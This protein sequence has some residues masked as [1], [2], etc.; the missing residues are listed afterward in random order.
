MTSLDLG[1]N[2]D[3]SNVTDMGAM[4]NYSGYTAMTSLDLGDKFNTSNVILMGGMFHSCGYT[5]MTSLDL[6]D[7][8]DTSN[9][10][11]M[12]GM[13][14]ECGHE[15]MTSLNLGDKFNTSEVT[16]MQYMFYG[17]GYTEMASLN[18]GEK[19]DTSSVTDMSYMFQLCGYN[20]MTDLDLGPAFTNIPSGKVTDSEENIVDAY[21]NMFQNTGKSGAIIYAPEAIY[22]NSTSFKLNGTDTSTEAGTIAVSSGRTVNPKYRPEWTVTGTTIDATN[23]ALKINIKGSTNSNYTSDVTTALT[24]EDISIWIDGTEV[25]GVTA[26][27]ST[28]NPTTGASITHTITITN[29]EETL[30]QAGKS[31]KEWSG[32]IALKIAGRGE[33]TDTYTKN[34][35]TDSYGNQ[36]MSATDETGTWV[37]V[38][39]K[40]DTIISENTPGKL[41]ADFITPEFTYEYA[42][43]TIDHGTKTV[44]IKFSVADKYFNTSKLTTDSTASNIAVE[45]DGKTTENA[46]KEL[47]KIEDIKATI[48]GKADTKVGETYQ[49][50]ISNLDQGE[51][52][53]YSGIT[54]L[55]F[56]EGVITDKSGNNSIATTITIGIDTPK[57]D[58]G[59]TSGVIVDV[60]SP[61][62]K[63]QNLLVDKTNKK[64]TIELIATDKYLTGV[65]NSTLTINDITL[66]VDGDVNANT[67]ITK[68]LSA[69]TF[70][71]NATTGMKEIKYTLTL[72]NWEEAT[73]QTGKTFL[74]YSGTAKITIAAGTVTDQYTNTN[75]EQTLTLGHIDVIKPRIE[76]VSSTRDASAKTET[77]VF[78]VIDKYLDTTDAVVASEI[79]VYVDKEKAESV[80]KTLTRVTANDVSATVNGTSQ[81]VSQQYKLVLTNFEKSR[82]A[83][84]TAR[85][86]TDWSGTVSI[87]IAANAVKDKTSGGSV[88]TNEATTIDADFVDYIQPKVTYKYATSDINYD[89]KTFIMKFEI[90]DKYYRE[91]TVITTDNLADYLTVKVDGEDITNNSKITKKIIATETITAGTSAKP[92]NKTINGTVQTGLIDQVVGKRYTLELSNLE[93]AINVGE[94]LNYSGVITVAVKAGTVTDRGPAGDNTNVNGNVTTTITSGVTIPGGTGTGTVV[95]VVDPIW[96][97][98]GAATTELK[99]RTA[100]LIIKGTDK[101][102]AS[103]SLTADKIKIVVND[104]EQTEG[105]TVEVTEDTSVTLA[106]GKQYKIKI[107]GFDSKAYQVKMIIPAGTL[108]DQSGNESK[109][110]EFLL[111]SCLKQTRTETEATSPFLENTALERQKIEKI[112]FQDNLDGVNSTRWD[113]SAQEDGSIIGWYETTSKGTYIV[114]IGG[115]N[116][117]YANSDSGYLFSYIGYAD[118]CTETE[119]IVNL[120]LLNVSNVSNMS[121]MFAYTGYRAM[122]SLDLGENFDTSN[123]TDMYAMFF[124]TGHEAM[125]NFNLRDNFDTSEVTTTAY[126]FFYTGYTSMTSLDL[127]NKFNTSKVTS[128]NA[129]FGNTGHTAMT[130]FNLGDNFDTSNVTDMSWMFMLLGYEKLTTLSLGDK[131]NTSKVTDMTGM[132]HYCG[133]SSMTTLDLG[134]NFDTSNVTTMNAMFHNCGVGKMTELNLGDKFNTISVTDMSGMFFYCGYT[135]M[136]TLNLG[137]KFDTSNVT[138][139]SNMFYKCGVM[140]LTSLDLGS[141]FDTNKVTNMIGMFRYCGNESLTNLSLGQAFTNIPGGTAENSDGTIS[142]AYA[143]MFLDVGKS[144]AVIN[145]PESIYKDRTSFKLSSTDT[146]TAAGTIAV[147]EGRIVVPK[148]KPEWTVTG[149][150][151]DTTNKKVTINLKGAVN[152]S[153]YTSNVTTSLTNSGISVWID[154][155]K[156]TGVTTAIT[157]ANPT[158]GASVTHTITI[159]NF[160]ETL[161]QAGKSYKEWSGN[162]ALRIDGRGEATSTYSKNI[163]VD[164]YG[165]QSMSE[166]DSSGTWIKV[167]LK[168]ETPSSANAAGKLFTD[169]ITPEFTY[170]YANT[171]IDHDTKTVTVKFSVADKYFSSST[172][173]A[174][175]TASNIGIEVD[176]K[177]TENATK[178]LTKIEDIKATID[179]KA[180]TKVGE[181]YQ[182]VISNLD[183]G[184][185]GDYS[186]IMKLTFALGTI[187]DQSN[188]KSIATTITIGIDDPKNDDGH[189]SGVIVD[190]V[191]PIWKTQNININKAAKKVTV[192]LIA[193]DKYLTGTENSTLTTNDITLTVDG[194]ANANTVITKSLSAGTFSTNTTT[195]LKE[196]KYTLTLSNWEEATKQTGKTFLEYSG[197]AKITIAAGAVIDQYTN[198]SEEQIF[199]LGHVDFIKPRIEK[200]SSTRDA[201]AKTETII[202]NVIDKYLDTTDAVAASEITAYVDGE[203][204]ST[205]TKTLTRVTA[206][207][208]SAI[209]NGT[210]QVVSQQYKL[211]LSNFEKARNAKNYKDWSGTVRIDI[212]ANAVKDKTSGGSVNTN[213]AVKIA[214]DFVDFIKPDLKYVH[215]SSDVNTDGKTYTMTFT[216]TDKYYTSGKLGVNDLTIKMQNGQKDSS[217]NEIVYNLKNEPVT[218]SLQAE[219]LNATNVPIT[220]NVTNGTIETK[221]SLQIGHTYKLIISNLEQ[222]EVKTGKTTADYSGIITVAV[223]GNKIS[224]KGPAGNN[225]SA[226]TNAATTI[227][228]GVNIPGG[229]SPDDAKAVDVVD[230][231]WEKISTSANAIDPSNKESSIATVTFKGTDTYYASNSLT[232]DKI[233][234]LVNGTEVTSGITKTLSAATE[235][236]E[237]RKEFGKTTTVTKQYGVQY[238][239]TVKGFT[240]TANQVKIQIPAGTLTDESGNTNKVTEMIIYNVLRSAESERDST[241]GFLGNTSIQRQ[242]IEN[243]TFETSIPSTI[244][245]ATTGTIV[246]TTTTWDVSAK[247]DKSIIAWYETGSASGILKVHIGSIG[248]I[249]ANQNS[250]YLFS[251]IGYA[252]GCKATTT[253]TNLNL[254]N[255]SGVTNMSSMFSNCGYAAMTNLDL[256]EN[257]DTSNVTDMSFMFEECGYTAMTNLELGNKFDTSNVTDMREMF[258]KCG[259]I[260]MTSLDLGGKFDTS[261]VTNMRDMFYRCGDTA[262]TSLNLGNNFNTSKVTNMYDMFFGTGHNSM[263]SLD[264]GDKFDTSNVTNMRDMF[265]RTGY[266]SM[267][268]LN[269]GDNFDT[270]KVTDMYGMF[271]MTGHNS[272][273]N[274]NLGDKFDTRQV[275]NMENMFYRCGYTAM[276]SLD[277]GDKFDTNSVTNMNKMFYGCGHKVMTTLNLGPAFTKIATESTD[278]MT[279]C[280]TTGLTIYAP[281]SIYSNKAE[282]YIK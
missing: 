246:N 213:D 282:F 258:M 82:T 79:T 60:V 140:S 244:Y 186:G 112:I 104:V 3:T 206:N 73:K 168:D 237:E 43:T 10:V 164:E 208:V 162:I 95:D 260:A 65:E 183:Q 129:M 275:T 25:K 33:S 2:F 146:S 20:K 209:V 235:L 132:F 48:D 268:S 101:Y 99:K 180:D 124:Y 7:N 216:I 44:T 211:V 226:N 271:Y 249:F 11:D 185:G 159:S 241:S 223:A 207:D 239:F 278:F 178:E 14:F 98:A 133:Y 114:H 1:D 256:G 108:V 23:K 151:I 242:N 266:N 195:G 115:Y 279:G 251:Y 90:T 53:D 274:L 177:T 92:I 193:T 63:A 42:N 257:F 93:Q 59:H 228:S 28:A 212:A 205:L 91:R 272:M 267:T 24:A 190:V 51:G 277:L 8:F 120:D 134:E 6:G 147:S 174:D 137:E 26:A 119:T 270:G 221:S 238:T 220:T 204:A 276:T 229:T 182:L 131:F 49:L 234:V 201:S 31:Y 199:T 47:T 214:G 57:N 39:F 40:D 181:T 106:Y 35:L 17:C 80:T 170:E 81:V 107:T 153:N 87:N 97:R 100:T 22:K 105:I 74:E 145:A 58:D 240:Q 139:M 252:S 32:N 19:F 150:T 130:S 254:L 280:G 128:M 72:S 232:A 89:D 4:F 154:G 70:S 36:S 224:D 161:R 245:N 149:T 61:I 34:V 255:T 96:E 56:A 125:I 219:N 127:G 78:N 138:N 184:G 225:T 64:A 191:S 9:V 102:F 188:N 113:V 16:Y 202:F 233:K 62:W 12:D 196:I 163:L 217:G 165:N 248:E 50:V 172:L 86:F 111:F 156:L 77:I 75:I 67:V 265:Y 41:F 152:T 262:M 116:G 227:T 198:K 5:A 27:V 259:L 218:I 192:E 110:T 94:Y 54:K 46:T 169:F 84:D 176:G 175:A 30:R 187:T 136:T 135:S 250:S 71:T 263:T 247:Q 158:T 200:V 269:L 85:D 189:T 55:S 18:L 103:S 118:I 88:N 66:T 148:Y 45:I 52:G 68:S 273:T 144:G 38:S 243:I 171:T 179:G 160:E 215:Q 194:D 197:T 21:M 37:D 155:T 253:I 222:L 264:L 76:K 203:N 236:K 122:T 13:F 117:I 29:F 281:E 167:E 15:A 143:N 157:A 166:I 231:I 83:I 261:N 173:T 210:S 230:P 121:Y 69:G 142:D 123:V 141:K 109:E 126:M